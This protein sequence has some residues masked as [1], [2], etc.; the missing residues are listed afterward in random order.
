MAKKIILRLLLTARKV[1][2]TNSHVSLVSFGSSKLDNANCKLTS[3]VTRYLGLLGSHVI[4]PCA[5]HYRVLTAL[6]IN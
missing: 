2:S 5:P 4:L 6:Y 1:G 3:H